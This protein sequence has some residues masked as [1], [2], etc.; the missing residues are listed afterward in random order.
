[1]FIFLG[2]SY[3]FALIADYAVGG[4]FGLFLHKKYTFKIQDKLTNLTIAK[5][6]FSN[7]TVFFINLI[8]IFLMID[9]LGYSPYF[10]QLVA[11]FII[12]LCL[13]FASI[14]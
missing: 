9:V 8:V 2:Y 14:V 11:L 13:I 6:V 3:T 4:L 10:S 5:A 1:M 12:V 7:L